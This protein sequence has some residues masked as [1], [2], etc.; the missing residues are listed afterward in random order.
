MLNAKNCI[1]IVISLFLCTILPI[2]VTPKETIEDLIYNTTYIYDLPEVEVIGEVTLS[3]KILDLA[4]LINSEAG[5]QS[6]EG[7]IAVG[8]VVRNIAR[9]KGWSI[10]KTIYD[11]NKH[12]PRFD[13]ITTKRFKEYPS[14][15][16]ILAAAKSA[17]VKI[18]PD[19]VHYFHNPKI[20]TDSKWVKY[21]EQFTWGDIQDHRFCFNPKK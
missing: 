7:K 3:S 18:V 21:I 15:E 19:N 5:N 12:G 2:N 20:S 8:N 9:D 11:R 1:Y 6:M 10:K 4:R 17:A 13:G 16:C 14:K